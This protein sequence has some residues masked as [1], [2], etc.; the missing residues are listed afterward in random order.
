MSI[1]PMLGGNRRGRRSPMAE[2]NVTPF[3]DVM[4]V[5]LIIFMV[6]APLLVTGVKVDLPDSS[7]GALDQEQKPVQIS[8]DAQGGLYIDEQPVALEELPERL[9]QLAGSSREEGG[10]RIFL[11]ADRAL[12]YGSVMKVMGEI[13]AAGLRRVAMVST[14]EGEPG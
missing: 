4:L 3:V 8:L 1:G 10:P 11:R 6:T 13:S 7:A 14:Q 2:I 9:A 12:D 5:L